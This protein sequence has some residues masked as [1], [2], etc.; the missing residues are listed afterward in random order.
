M[1]H[2][3]TSQTLMQAPRLDDLLHRRRLRLL[4]ELREPLHEIFVRARRLF[5][6]F[7][8]RLF[9]FLGCLTTGIGTWD[10]TYFNRD[11]DFWRIAEPG[12]LRGKCA[13]V[14]AKGYE[15]FV[16]Q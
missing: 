7:D 14:A 5:H 13:E 9:V 6:R 11:I 16:L 10:M 2:Q 8:S 15:G 1:E 12:F 3:T 4:A